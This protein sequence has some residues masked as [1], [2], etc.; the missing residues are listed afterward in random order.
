MNDTS[1]PPEIGNKRGEDALVEETVDWL[2]QRKSEVESTLTL[3]AA[4]IGEYLIERFFKGDLAE[5]TSRNPNKNVSFQKL[6]E[7]E[8]LPFSARALRSF[9]QV[10]DGVPMPRIG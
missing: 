8:D 3:Q 2:R 1:L 6:C 10:A 5:V 9:I 4:Q 7:R